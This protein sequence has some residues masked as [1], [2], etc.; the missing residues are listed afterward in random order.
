VLKKG[1][2]S[3]PSRGNPAKKRL[4]ATCLSPFSTQGISRNAL[5]QTGEI[6]FIS[7]HWWNLEFVGWFTV[8][9]IFFFILSSIAKSLRKIANK[10]DGKEKT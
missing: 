3:E 2:G 1:P 5:L 4:D 6:M 9:V 7:E 8:A 10:C